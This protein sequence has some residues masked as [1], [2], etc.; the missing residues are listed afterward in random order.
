MHLEAPGEGRVGGLV[1]GWVEHAPPAERVDD[2]R[3]AQVAAVGVNGRPGAAL[4]LGGVEL[5]VALVGEQGAQ[6]AVV[7]GREAPWQA[8]ARVDVRGVDDEVREG[9]ADRR[10]EA[11]RV[12][13]PCRGGAGGG[14]ALADLVAVDD[15]HARARA[16][17]LARDGEAR[18]A[19]AAD[20]DVR[21]GGE[22]SALRAALRLAAGHGDPALQR[23][24]W[25]ARGCR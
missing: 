13:P 25:H 17:E 6:L 14:L 8:V 21:V 18:E 23:S 10:V 7:E 2:E 15:E 12:E 5:G 1:A 3:R 22:R 20:Q 9:L 24:S 19:R 11:E 4:D 16:R